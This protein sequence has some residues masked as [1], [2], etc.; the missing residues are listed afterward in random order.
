MDTRVKSGA[1]SREPI[2][3]TVRSQ[4]FFAWGFTLVWNA[5]SMPAAILLPREIVAGNYAAAAGLMFPLI[6]AFLL[7]WPIRIHR[8]Y[9]L[10]GDIELALDPHPGSIGGHV[11]GR[12]LLPVTAGTAADYMVTLMCVH[13]YRRRSGRKR[14]WKEKVFWHTRG[15]AVAAAATTGLELQ[16]RFDVP[17]ELPESAPP[18][19]SY[20]FWKLLVE[21]DH[22][23][24]SLSRT[25]E[26]PVFATAE[27]AKSIDIDSAEMERIRARSRVN[28]ALRDEKAAER[29]RRTKGL[30][31]EVRSDWIRLYFHRG[32]HKAMAASLLFVGVLSAATFWMEDSG[33]TATLIRYVFGASGAVMIASAAYIPLNTLDVRVNR[34]QIVRVRSWLGL[35]LKRQ[36]IAPRALREIVIERGASSS[37]GEITYYRLIGRGTFGKFCFA[38]GIDDRAVLEAL[39]EKIAC[40]AG[41]APDAGAN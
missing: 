30:S 19:R 18:S 17:E 20:Y 21:S 36:T 10:F 15:P 40:F 31:L 25:F 28:D 23:P 3:S 13:R 35:V 29:L 32:R 34:K 11:G 22:E 2:R 5:V 1:E 33:L 8:E 4:L 7:L 39:R 9:R 14:R 16:F 24:L 38:E 6:G 26:I 37:N 12:V 27:H 41:L